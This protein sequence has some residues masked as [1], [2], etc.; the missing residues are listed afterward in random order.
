MR[1]LRSIAQ[2][3]GSYDGNDG[4][5]VGIQLSRSNSNTLSNNTCEGNNGG[6][7]SA[8]IY[9]DDLSRYNKITQ[10]TCYN[11]EDAGIYIND[12]NDNLL[13]GND[14]A[15][16]KSGAASGYGIYV[17]MSYSTSVLNNICNNNYYG[18][19]LDGSTSSTITG[20]KCYNNLDAEASSGIF[21]GDSC[22]SNTLK[23]NLCYGNTHGIY[24]LT[25]C[26]FN[27][28]EGNWCG[29]NNQSGLY[30][31]GAEYNWITVN[32]CGQFIYD[33]V[34][35]NGNL[36]GI[37]LSCL[38]DNNWITGN[39]CDYNT[40][41]GI[42]LNSLNNAGEWLWASGNTL[43]SNNCNNNATGISL[44]HSTATT[45]SGN[46]LA[47]NTSYGIYI[48]GIMPQATRQPAIRLPVMTMV[49]ML[50]LTLPATVS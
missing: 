34:T 24:L 39:S 25:N 41:A 2:Y 48:S 40:E 23:E 45:L 1:F 8:G 35:Y 12:S 4:N 31:F 10:N 29:E 18:I 6:D 21:L 28:I 44:S 19:Y 7:T 27:Q 13:S 42:L 50:L 15:G 26:Q 20:N 49:Y 46:E 3:S 30:L 16:H 14:C 37:Y 33:S 9:L 36:T 47:D 43:S 11:N 32:Y 5:N 17:R 22:G 38:A